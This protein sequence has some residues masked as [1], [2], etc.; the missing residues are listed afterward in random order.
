MKHEFYTI[1]GKVLKRI[2]DEDRYNNRYMAVNLTNRNT[3]EFRIMRGTLNLESFYACIDFITTLALEARYMNFKST[4]KDWLK[5]MKPET[6]RY[7]KNRGCSF[8]GAVDELIAERN[9]A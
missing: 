7:L 6:L 5:K 2:V 4:A 9:V 1:T 3:I 8:D